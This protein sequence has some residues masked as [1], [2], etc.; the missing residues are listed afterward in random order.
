MKRLVLAGLLATLAAPAI[1]HAGDVAM[2]VR[3]VPLGQRALAAGGGMNFNML[4]LHW[5]G[6]GS[7]EYRTRRLHGGW[8]AWRTADADEYRTGAWHDGNLEWTGASAAAQF[9]V[10]GVIHRLRS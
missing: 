3:D 6:R 4:G 10:H 9:R 8:R 7:V 5:I 1:A 2:R